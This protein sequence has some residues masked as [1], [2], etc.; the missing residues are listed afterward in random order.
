MKKIALIGSTGSI[1]RQV[2]EVVRGR[3]DL[4]KIVALVAGSS[5]EDFKPV[6][7]QKIS[8]ILQTALAFY[9]AFQK[10]PHLSQNRSEKPN[11]HKRYY[12]REIACKLKKNVVEAQNYGFVYAA[13]E[14]H[15]AQR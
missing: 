14:V 10:V 5:S 4:F 11:K 2:L 13:E 6:P 3:R 1:G 8:H 7:G 15:Y 12:V 9:R